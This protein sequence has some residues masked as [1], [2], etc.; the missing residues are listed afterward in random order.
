LHHLAWA[1][2]GPT[3]VAAEAAASIG[4]SSV[5]LLA[6]SITDTWRWADVGCHDHKSAR[7]GK[8]MFTLPY[9]SICQY[10]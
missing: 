7:C 8:Q 3:E 6:F 10:A 9:M 1:G 5:P 4:V 2:V